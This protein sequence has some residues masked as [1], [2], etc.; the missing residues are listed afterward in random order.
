MWL[1]GMARA[2]HHMKC[3]TKQKLQTVSAAG[4]QK[5]EV[6]IGLIALVHNLAKIS[7]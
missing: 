4:Y 3:Q 6:E 7:A 2:D 1:S 5:V